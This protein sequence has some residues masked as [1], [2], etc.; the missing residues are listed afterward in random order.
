MLTD[1]F[2]PLIADWFEQSF[3]EPTEAQA[4]AWP[5][6]AARRH[7]LVAAPTGSGKTLA[8]FL[9]SIDTLLRQAADHSLADETQVV[10][11]SPLKAL[12]NDIH[13]NLTVPLAEIGEAATAA[14]LGLTPIRTAVR[15]GDTPSR[16]RQAMLKKP[17]HILVTTPESLYLLL[18]APK[19]REMLRRVRA[20]IVD[21]IHAL[22]RDKRGSHLALTLARLD[23]LCDAPPVRIGLSATQRPIDEIARFLVGTANV[24][25]AGNAA[26]HIVDTGHVRE[27]DLAVEVPPSELSAVCPVETWQ[28]AY[29]RLAQLISEHR[30]TLV[31]VNTRRLAERVAHYLEELLG[32]GHVASHHGSLSR[33]IRLHA[34]ERLKS[35]ELKAIVAT[36]S[37]ELGIDIGYIDLVCQIG[38]PRSIA[39]FLQRVGRAGH[40]IGRVPKGRLFALTRDELLESLALVR[41]VRQSKLDRVEIPVAPLDILAQQIVAAVACDE[42]SEDE[43][44]EMCRQAWPYRRLERREFDAVVA[45]LA[46]GIAPGNRTGAY[47]HR[48]QIHHRLRARRSARIAAITSGGAIP[49]MADYRVVMEGERTFVGTLN[50]DFAIESQIGNVFQLG[51]AS[52]RV[53]HVRGGEVT[54]RD[55]HGAAATVPFWLGEAP[56]R[57]PELSAE[58]S[59]LRES[60]RERAAESPASVTAW[61]KQECGADDWAAEQAVNYVLSQLAAIGLVPTQRQIVFERFFDESGGMQLVIHAPFGARINRA[62]GLALRKCFCRTFDFELQASA[63]DNGIVLSIGPNHSFP[64]DRMFN[65]LTTADAEVL[66]IQALLAVPMFQ[67]RWRWNVTRA[68]AVLRQRGGKKV[69]PHLQRFKAE[70]L[71]TA[72][73]PMQTACFEHR[74]G[75]LEPPDHPLI[76]QTIHDCLHEVMDFDG[77]L[78][79]LRDIEAGRIE[80]LARDTR[81]PSPFSHQ[82]I[83]ANVYAFLD[84]A[85]LEERRARAVAARRTIR[86]E[87]MRDLGRLDPAA[88]EQVR[89]DAWPVVRDAEEL[90]D[91]LLTVGALN[92]NEATNWRCYFDT[93]IDAGRATRCR[94]TGGQV[95]W[96]AAENWPVARTTLPGAVATPPVHLPA[97]L[98]RDVS[99]ND[100]RLQLVRGRIEIAGPTT[101]A[102][103]ANQLGMDAASVGIALEQLEMEGI[104]LR[105]Q[106]TGDA[107]NEIEWCERRLL[108]RIHRLTLDGLRRQVEPVDA[109]ALFRF[110]IVWHGMNAGRRLAGKGD[111][112][113]AVSLLEGFEAPAGVWEHELLPAR[114]P[115]YE[116]EWLDEQ[117]AAG[118]LVWGRL[119][120]PP[121]TDDR[122]GQP[123]TRSVPISVLRRANLKWLLPPQRT[124][125]PDGARWDAQGAY[126]ALASHGALFF[127][128]L[129]AAT[130]L[131]PAQLEEAL[132]ELAALGLVTSDGFAAIRSLMSKHHGPRRRVGRR[133]KGRIRR[134]AYAVGGRWSKFPPFVRPPETAERVEH[135]AWL[136]LRR[137]GV[138]FR[139]LL[140]RESLAPAWSELARVY[141]RME[142][143]GEIRGG[144]FVAGV[145][146]EQFALPDV[147]EHLRK[148]RDVSIG[149]TRLH[150]WQIIS[151]ADPLNL[152]GIITEGPRVPATRTNRILLRDGQPIAAREAGAIRWL[153][154]VDEAS[155]QHAA[156]FLAGPDALRR[157]GIAAVTRSMSLIGANGRSASENGH[158]AAGSSA[159][160][161]LTG[162]SLHWPR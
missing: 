49:E 156:R 37:L 62:W 158:Q 88:I 71:L 16:D 18:T 89:A 108:A 111:L 125:S 130:D 107:T 96:I 142:M 153:A 100:G 101:A 54:V 58:L 56:G 27:L 29:A 25:A 14:G 73:F 114:L 30:S 17:P 46:D 22:A 94:T 63:D 64:L 72:I 2:H 144:R 35:G 61:L 133:Q 8:A 83:N 32:K 145:A 65:L 13:R 91:A 146:G 99:P 44:F 97:S 40:A 116:P 151:A 48:D 103:I 148:F 60:V 78:E 147:V 53:V 162:I 106:F 138:M 24:D 154:V 12:S 115:G 143:R 66:L 86:P 132:S 69:P 4:K 20:V 160:A 109:A 47:L 3:G 149:E 10:Y 121:Q 39:T 127:D 134:K 113:A 137:Y 77:W 90:H 33:E 136:L 67:I 1:L 68:L 85:P 50:E 43:L 70:D 120:P 79:I 74:T 31:F 52:W 161:D 150:E 126:E 42:W 55:A 75:D 95:L 7:T 117:F 41:A 157:A 15:T 122:R 38:S 59:Q 159:A 124:V 119:T 23:Q 98:Q 102:R 104:V 140:A 105:G 123:L 45:M 19:S 11:V 92:E 6:I 135:W 34:E 152:I 129:L 82:L 128:D 21:E 76:R 139:D 5:S 81:E 36:A 155:R 87:D 141:R 9:A 80:L 84:D 93:L 118:E 26:C 57:T 51:N 28:E 131:L 110:L 112:L